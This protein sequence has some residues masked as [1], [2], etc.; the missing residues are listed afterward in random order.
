MLQLA[1]PAALTEPSYTEVVVSDGTGFRARFSRPETLTGG[2]LK[3]IEAT[4]M[5][6]LLYLGHNILGCHMTNNYLSLYDG[7]VHDSVFI[8]INDVP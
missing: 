1:C 4:C 5:L 6:L 3:L 7:G 2:R 8:G